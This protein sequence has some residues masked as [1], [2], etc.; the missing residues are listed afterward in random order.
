MV[1]VPGVVPDKV[2]GFWLVVR[3]WALCSSCEACRAGH[4]ARRSSRAAGAIASSTAAVFQVLVFHPALM[5]L[6]ARSRLLTPHRCCSRAPSCLRRRSPVHLKPSHSSTNHSD[7]A[8]QPVPADLS[9]RVPDARLCGLWTASPKVFMSVLSWGNI[10]L[11]DLTELIRPDY[12]Q[13]GGNPTLLAKE[14]FPDES[15]SIAHGSIWN[16]LPTEF[17]VILRAAEGKKHSS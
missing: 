10:K 14:V 1:L 8:E 3:K 15:Y 9:R 6:P 13:F 12:P 17:N 16:G 7:T 2:H 5:H 4:E 11:M